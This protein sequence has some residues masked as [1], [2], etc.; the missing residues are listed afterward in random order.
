MK[1]LRAK[2]MLVGS[3]I[4]A[5]TIPLGFF[6]VGS[7]WDRLCGLLLGISGA[8]IVTGIHFD[9]VDPKKDGEG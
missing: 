5:I 7:F 3:A 2:Y 6:P 1:S 4:M 8:M 9:L